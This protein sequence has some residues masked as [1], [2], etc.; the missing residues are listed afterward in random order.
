MHGGSSIRRP[1]SLHVG[2]Q[3]TIRKGFAEVTRLAIRVLHPT[4]VHLRVRPAITLLLAFCCVLAAAGQNDG[5]TEPAVA[6]G[7]AQAG[8]RPGPFVLPAG[9]KV[10]RDLIYTGS[11]SSGE[12]LDL[13]L[14]AAGTGPF[15]GIVFIHGG[16]WSA[17]S[18]NDFQRQAAHLAT[19]G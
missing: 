6:P 17:G 7:S 13:F 3:N 1:Q 19:Q 9:V 12:K 10:E 15:P 14:P 8:A 16:A 5:R 4:R 2:P 11:Q 18:K